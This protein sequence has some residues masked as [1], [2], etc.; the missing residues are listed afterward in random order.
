VARNRRQAYHPCRNPFLKVRGTD[1]P[2]I[3]P[4]TQDKLLKH[5]RADALRL[6]NEFID[7]PVEYVPFIEEARALAEANGGFFP[8][9][10]GKLSRPIE[11]E[12]NRLAQRA[13]RRC[14]MTVSKLMFYLHPAAADL[15]PFF[16]LITHALAGNVDSVSMLRRD[17]MTPFENPLTG[18]RCKI[19]LEKP[20][21]GGSLPDYQV[22][23]AGTL[24]VPWLFRAVLRMTEPLVPL[25][26]PE[27]KHLL[28]ISAIVQREVAPIVGLLRYNAMNIFLRTH[29]LPPVT[30][31][32][33]RPTRL[34]TDYKKHRDIFRTQAIARQK[35][36]STTILY[37]DHTLAQEADDVL[38][39]GVQGDIQQ[40]R[41]GAG[42][43]QK[44]RVPAMHLPS[45]TCS[46][47]SDPTK[48][49]DA[50]GICVNLLWPLNDRHFIMP[51]EPRPVA[52]LLRDYQELCEAQLRLP[53]AR[54][55]RYA[56]KKRYIEE[57]YLP[58]IDEPLREAAL[59]LIPTL[60]KAPRID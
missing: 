40:N 1:L 54:F 15:M 7:P 56:P 3:E 41:I 31:Q 12:A 37:L 38:I 57:H 52:F 20:R 24:S 18:K 2:F 27:L 19:V 4:A 11:H 26:R 50:N 58:S 23:D 39:A 51:L 44:T 34:I 8:R 30:L 49:H 10:K 43:T 13:Y 16:I 29:S 36:P 42:A 6:Y 60:P 22:A 55:A 35:S 32:A 28:F 21:A 17:A 45:H 59:A 46:H 48:E 53:A 5:A 33:I 9:C 14:G 25:A 47:P